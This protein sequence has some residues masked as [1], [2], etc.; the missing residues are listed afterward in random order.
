MRLSSAFQ[1]RIPSY[2][3]A[4]MK[5]ARRDRVAHGR[6]YGL[7][8]VNPAMRLGRAG[9]AT[10]HALGVDACHA[11]Y[12]ETLGYTMSWFIDACFPAALV[13]SGSTSS[14]AR[15]VRK[16]APRAKRDGGSN[17]SVTVGCRDEQGIL[18]NDVYYGPA[19]INNPPCGKKMA[20]IPQVWQR[21]GGR[22]RS[23]ALKAGGVA[24]AN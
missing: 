15:V 20:F 11:G 4:R 17:A 12:V 24:R 10:C 5:A 2:V 16:R 7:G 8:R 3:Y 18:V 21:L 1:P 6:V 14:R 9:S 22:C 19:C 13:R 23:E